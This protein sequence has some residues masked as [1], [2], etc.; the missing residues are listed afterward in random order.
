MSM[1]PDTFV[2]ITDASGTT[3]YM[4]TTGSHSGTSYDFGGL[5]GTGPLTNWGFTIVVAT[6]SIQVV[7]CVPIVAFFYNGPD[8]G[9]P[10]HL[11]APTVAPDI[12]ILS[13]FTSA[14]T[15]GGGGPLSYTVTWVP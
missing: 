8:L 6:C 1:P 14:N 12:S 9:L 5:Y 4:S 15:G 2:Y 11:S 13:I 3:T 10:I 7:T